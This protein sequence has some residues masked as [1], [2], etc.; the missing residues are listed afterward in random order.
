MADQPRPEGENESRSRR[1]VLAPLGG[2]GATLL[3]GVGAAA[4]GGVGAYRRDR[5]SEHSGG[6]GIPDELK[7]SEAFHERLVDR[8]G[9]DS[10]EGL[11]VGRTDFLVDARYVGTAAVDDSVKRRLEALFRD[12]GIHMQWLDHPDRIDE[13]RFL[14]SYGNDVHSILWATQSFYA[15]EV[16]ADLKNVAFQL[17][18][19]PGRREP[20]HV[21]RV[22]CHLSDG[23]RDRWNDGWVNGM[24]AGNRA[25]VGHRD[26]PREQAR[27]ALHEIAHLVL[28]HDDDPANTGEMGTQ[29]RLDLTDDEWTE[30]RNGLDAVRDTTGYDVAFRRCSWTEYVPA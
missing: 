13:R 28:C 6:D 20:P 22:Y 1:S 30:L 17:V 25:V 11:E 24:N 16:E 15:R 10:F 14:E 21:G 23:L 18:V 29:Q 12:N 4:A 2:T 19:V 3:G 27:L 8:F 9:A 5:A 26:S 7:R